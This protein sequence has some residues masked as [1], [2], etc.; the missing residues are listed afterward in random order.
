MASRRLA[1]SLLLVSMLALLTACGGQ[2][3]DRNTVDVSGVGEI[4]ATP[5]RFRVRAVSSRTGDDIN[6]MKQEV[7]AEIRA[8]LSLANELGL[9]ERLVRA[10]GINISPEWQWQPERKIIGHQ[11][12]R[13]IDMA[14]DG[15]EAYAELLEGMTRLGFKQ[16][17]QVGAELAEATALE[18]QAFEEAMKDA[19]NKAGILANA[20]GR[21]LG[22]AIVIQEQGGGGG[23]QPMMAMARDTAESSSAYSPG[24]ITLRKQIQVRFEMH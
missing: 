7:D 19:R 17:Q 22:D 3:A 8:A 4:K 14:V 23:H 6:A 12:S 16:L 1:G 5:D 15:V 24:E 13:D 11:V 2:P 10:T 20:A 9:E 18:N 21:T